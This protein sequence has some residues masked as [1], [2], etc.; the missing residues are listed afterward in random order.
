MNIKNGFTLFEALIAIT[1][2]ITLLGILLSIYVLSLKSLNSGQDRSELTQESRIIIERIT[3][4]IRETRARTGTIPPTKDDPEIP[5]PSGI[6]LQDGHNEALQYIKYYASGTDLRRQMRKY[7]FSS[8]PSVFVTHDAED[9]FG[10]EPNMDI[11]SDELI[12]K[13]IDDI[14]FFGTNPVNIELA[15]KKRSVEHNTKTAVYGRNL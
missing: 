15:L 12:G 4:D 1:I 11:I 14:K 5:A 6:E 9:D 10:N 3:R 7:Y 2:G 13:F 8:D